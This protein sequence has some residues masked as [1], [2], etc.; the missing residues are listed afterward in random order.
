M[1]RGVAE[2]GGS[3][4]DCDLHDVNVILFTQTGNEFLVRL[5]GGY[6]RWRSSETG[7]I[8]EVVLVREIEMVFGYATTGSPDPNVDLTGMCREIGFRLD[9]WAKARTPLRFVAAPRKTSL[10]FDPHRGVVVPIPRSDL[11]CA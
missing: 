9:E 7:R 6:G 1:T 11:D 4:L 2:P 5:G 10:L 8:E 3:D